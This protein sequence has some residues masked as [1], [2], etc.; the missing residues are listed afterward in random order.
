VAGIPA[1]GEKEPLFLSSGTWSLV[2]RELLKP[3]VSESTFALGF[4]NEQGVGETTRFLKNVAGMWLLQECKRAWDGKRA[5]PVDYGHLV[6]QARSSRMKSLIDPD[7]ESFQR[8][9]DMPEAIIAY[10]ERTGQESPSSMGDITRVILQSLAIK[11]RE[12]IED[13]RGLTSSLPETIHVVGGGSQNDLLNQMTA[14]A[15]G[16]CVEAG[17]VEATAAGNILAQLMAAGEID[18]L[19]QG[20]ELLRRSFEPRVFEPQDFP[21]WEET[22]AHFHELASRS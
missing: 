13:L 9:C 3:L 21:I 11:Y 19:A 12:V 10:L 6:E 20:R 15:T 18:S 2:G 17:P 7:H 5:Q 4:S 16:L 22:A 14:D 8:P 1:S